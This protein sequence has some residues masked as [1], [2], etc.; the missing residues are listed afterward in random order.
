MASNSWPLPIHTPSYNICTTTPLLSFHRHALTKALPAGG[1]GRPFFPPHVV[2]KR[3]SL[4]STIYS[5][6]T[7]PPQP[8]P[9]KQQQYDHHLHLDHH[10]KL[11]PNSCPLTPVGFLE[12]A[13]VV[14][15]EC[16]SIIYNETTQTWSETYT[17]CLKLA[18]A[19]SSLRI[20]K[21]DVVSVVA[22][23][24]PA[25]YEL[26]FAVPMTNAI[27]NTIN[28]RLDAR[29]I[30]V[31]LQHCES[32]LVFVDH[33]STN[34]ILDAIS[35]FP[36]HS[37][38]P[39]IILISEPGFDRNNNSNEFQVTFHDNTYEDMVK[40]GDLD[41]DWVPPEDEW[42]PMTL[43]YTSGT[44]SSPKGVLHSH[45]ARFIQSM[46]GLMDWQLPKQSTY[47]WTLPMFHSNGWSYT[48]STAAV[49]AVNV[50]LRRVD[51]PS[52]FEAIDKHGVTHMCGAP[53]VLNM[54][55]NFPAQRGKLE[56]PVHILTAG[57]PPPAPVRDRSKD[58][59]ICGGENLSSVEV[60]SVLYT[61]PAVNEAAVVARP[62]KFWGETPCAFVSLK[63]EAEV[64][65][66]EKDV[67]EFCKA[68]LPLYMVPRTVMFKEEL[69]KTSTG[70][71]QKFLLRELARRL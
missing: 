2:H 8:P 48:W 64:K 40:L 50:C 18:S 46:D 23:N 17:R 52:V 42:Q 13:A 32:K 22:P 44:T 53:A 27:L 33:Q 1:A 29:N 65:P 9:P 62:D 61:H 54:L 24:I 35:Q 68:R 63:A 3:S 43:N 34:V 39:I 15:G 16:P 66:S 71:I 30:S 20:K 47:L 28:L 10:H 37:K 31:L 45:R 60:E 69:P 26:H 5:L 4:Y 6:S 38:K 70:K 55:S 41:F 59:I 57:S 12:R 19:I 51:A 14:Y 56:H 67:R 7:P 49:G 21:G 25:M 36:P 11:S 58:V